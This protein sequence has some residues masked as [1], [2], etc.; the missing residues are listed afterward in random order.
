MGIELICNEDP[1]VVWCCAYCLPDVRNKVRLSASITNAGSDLFSSRNFEV[2]NQAL[3]AVANVFVFLAF[4]LARLACNARLH[5]FCGICAFK[6]LDASLLICAH[7]MDALRVQRRSLLIKIAHRFD[8][9]VKLWCVSLR[10]SEPVFN[11]IGF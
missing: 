6:S 5:R 10:G 11:P 2:G 7:K 1:L 8:L 9:L 4:D 3:R